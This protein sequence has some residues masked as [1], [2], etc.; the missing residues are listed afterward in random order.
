MFLNLYVLVIFWMLLL[1]LLRIRIVLFLYLFMRVWY[2]VCDWIICCFW[3]VIL[4]RW[5]ESLLRLIF[6]VM[7]LEFVRKMNGVFFFCSWVS[8]FWVLGMGFLLCINILLMLKVKVML[9]CGEVMLL[10]ELE[11]GRI[12]V[13]GLLIGCNVKSVRFW[14]SLYFVLWYVDVVSWILSW[15]D[16]VEVYIEDWFD[17]DEIVCLKNDVECF[18]FLLVWC[19]YMVLNYWGYGIMVIKG[20][21]CIIYFFMCG[22]LVKVV[23]CVMFLC[24]FLLI[25]YGL[26]IND[27]LIVL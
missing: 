17:V 2:G 6:L 18:C 3:K 1:V 8:V 27:G 11:F 14:I 12:C 26:K 21:L 20:L 16:F 23:D 5:R 7:L 22:G 15:W 19:I 9:F 25:G 24:L 4:L 13:G 10:V